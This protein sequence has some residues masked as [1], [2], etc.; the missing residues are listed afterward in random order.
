MSEIAPEVRVRIGPWR[1]QFLN[2]VFGGAESVNAILREFDA[3]GPAVPA[4]LF[5][6][7]A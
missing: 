6:Q 4:A 2:Q 1:R 3:G 7:K 5:G